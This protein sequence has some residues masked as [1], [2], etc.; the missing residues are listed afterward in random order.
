LA[1]KNVRFVNRELGSGSRALLD[2]LL[3]KGGIDCQKVRGYDRV[4][5]GHLA[6]AY[7]VLSREV[8]ACLAT[9]SAAL[10]FG[11]DFIPLHRERYDLVMRRRTA[12]LP[13]ARALLDVLQRATLRR[14]LEVLAGYD[15]SET[16]S[17]VA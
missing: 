3:A 6:A 10:A 16:G 7:R 11:L 9:R 8:D 15:T 12:D 14:K 1:Q 5:F 17:L 13:A 4:A 2:R